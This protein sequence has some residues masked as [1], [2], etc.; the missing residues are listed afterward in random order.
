MCRRRAARRHSTEKLAASEISTRK[1][2]FGQCAPENRINLFSAFKSTSSNCS[3]Q[4][5]YVHSA[6]GLKIETNLNKLLV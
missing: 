1:F 2:N 6:C 4:F 3:A 5:D